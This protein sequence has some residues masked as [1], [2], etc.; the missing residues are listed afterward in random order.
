MNCRMVDGWRRGLVALIGGTLAV[1][2]GAGSVAAAAVPSGVH[3]YDALRYDY[4][5]PAVEAQ[6]P[7]ANSTLA[8]A[9]STRFDGAATEAR[10]HV[11]GIYDS[12]SSRVAPS[13]TRGVRGLAGA[14]DELA[15]GGVYA[16]RDPVT[17]QVVRTGRTNSL[18]RRAGEH[19]RDPA[20]ADF[21]FEVI[22][23]TDV[24]AQQRGLEQL[25]HD[26]YSPA[27]NRIRPVSRSNPAL[28]TYMDAADDFLSVYGG[29]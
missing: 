23:R 6:D 27:L 14:G 12:V 11:D 13:V 24:Y 21:E 29:G 8:A 2:L 15:Q 16:L 9:R 18:T 17:G 20:L 28:T 25:A 5:V 4:G 7:A 26:A 1:V 3:D 10:G 22:A 19:L